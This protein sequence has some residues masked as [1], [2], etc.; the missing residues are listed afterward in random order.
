MRGGAAT[1]GAG[2]GDGGD[3]G[4]GGGGAG[5]A[6]SWL[7]AAWDAA[8]LLPVAAADWLNEQVLR[9]Q[10]GSMSSLQKCL[11]QP[12]PAQKLPEQWEGG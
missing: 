8:S 5:R 3:E 12:Q 1:G 9:A 6:S 7:D 2:G 4:D 10:L 11:M